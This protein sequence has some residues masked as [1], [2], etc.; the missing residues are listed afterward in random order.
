MT[1]V[2]LNM[3]F[4]VCPSSILRNLNTGMLWHDLRIITNPFTTIHQEDACELR[5]Q[6]QRAGS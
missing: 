5:G 6:N 3:Y 1:F 4:S 2:K